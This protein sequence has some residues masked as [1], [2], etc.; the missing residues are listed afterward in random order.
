MESRFLVDD[1]IRH[2]LQHGYRRRQFI[3]NPL[4][5]GIGSIFL[6]KVAFFNNVRKKLLFWEIQ[7][8]IKVQKIE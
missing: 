2:Y 1:Q 4:L 6:Q 5:P 3:S 7:G 8:H